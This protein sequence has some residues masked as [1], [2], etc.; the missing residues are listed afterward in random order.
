MP[1]EAHLS[2]RATLVPSDPLRK[3]LVMELYDP[4][5]EIA[6]AYPNPVDSPK[7]RI[8]TALV[9]TGKHVG[10]ANSLVHVRNSHGGGG[11]ATSLERYKGHGT[12]LGRKMAGPIH[13]RGVETPSALKLLGGR[14]N[15][16]AGRVKAAW[17][18]PGSGVKAHRRGLAM[19]QLRAQVGKSMIFQNGRSVGRRIA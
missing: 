8:L 13:K 12:K 5:Q 17:A 7:V 6:K 4:F 2:P 19:E 18:T 11:K 15:G 1:S 9:P 3:A 10:S 14:S 16:T